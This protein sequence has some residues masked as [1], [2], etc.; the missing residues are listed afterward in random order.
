MI[1][2]LENVYICHF[3]EHLQKIKFI[4][5][6]NSVNLVSPSKK[7]DVSC[8]STLV[9]CDQVKSEKHASIFA[10]VGLSPGLEECIV[11]LLLCLHLIDVHSLL[12]ACWLH[13]KFSLL[14]L[15]LIARLCKL[16]PWYQEFTLQGSIFSNRWRIL[17]IV[18]LMN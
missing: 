4:F 7:V 17:S 1:V 6:C 3:I 13:V 8:V 2:I 15:S 10:W 11:I 9:W 18:S 16:N 14:P 12:F 5:Y